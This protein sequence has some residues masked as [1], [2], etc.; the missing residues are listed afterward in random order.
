MRKATR[1]LVRDP[2]GRELAVPSLD[3]LHALYDQGFLG[4]EDLVRQEKGGDWVRAGSMPALAG[5]RH[6]RGGPRWV[7]TV[8]AAAVALAAAVGLLLAGR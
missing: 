3:D 5:A 1:Y 6:R 8:L 7:L 4:D 2:S